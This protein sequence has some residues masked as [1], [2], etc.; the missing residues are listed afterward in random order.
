MAEKIK[1]HFFNEFSRVKTNL[2]LDLKNDNCCHDHVPP[3]S[4]FFSLPFLRIIV[5]FRSRWYRSTGLPRKGIMGTS[6]CRTLNERREGLLYLALESPLRERQCL[7]SLLCASLGTERETTNLNQ[8]KFNPGTEIAGKFVPL[9]TS[10]VFLFR[11]SFPAFSSF[12]FAHF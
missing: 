11:Y 3:S 5:S 6:C 12:F 8:L 1:R 7:P 2:W 10:F 4:L 9:S